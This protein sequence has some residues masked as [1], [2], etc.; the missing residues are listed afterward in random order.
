MP[1]HP[2]TFSQPGTP[3]FNPYPPKIWIASLAILKAN[4]VARTLEATACGPDGGIVTALYRAIRRVK[5][6]MD[7]TMAN[8]LNSFSLMFW[9]S[10]MAFPPLEALF[11]VLEGFVKRSL[12]QTRKDDAHSAVDF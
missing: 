6:R 8:I 12:S 9:C 5:D 11:R 1:W 10:K 4:S 3:C 2:E 7:S